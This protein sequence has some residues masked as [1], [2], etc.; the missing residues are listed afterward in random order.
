MKKVI[1]GLLIGLVLCFV[2]GVVLSDFLWCV[3]NYPIENYAH[4][5]YY[6]NNLFGRFIQP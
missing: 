6:E 2:L 3:E 5:L 4:C 1:V